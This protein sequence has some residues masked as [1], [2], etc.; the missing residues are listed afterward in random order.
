VRGKLAGK[1]ASKDDA[2]LE[3]A[4]APILGLAAQCQ[5][6]RGWSPDALSIVSMTQK[7]WR[8][9]CQKSLNLT[10]RHGH[11]AGLQLMAADAV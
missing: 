9:G 5:C 6:A 10:D 8:R 2:A 1:A 11:V 4:S 7:P 3:S